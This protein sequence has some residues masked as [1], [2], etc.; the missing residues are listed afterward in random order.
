V[1]DDRR[2]MTFKIFPKTVKK[3][4]TRDGIVEP[5]VRKQ[6]GFQELYGRTVIMS[7]MGNV[8]MQL[9]LIQDG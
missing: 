5:D 7:N 1:W 3:P 8:E 4:S 6:D 2:D 9:T